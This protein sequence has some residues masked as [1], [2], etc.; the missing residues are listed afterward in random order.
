MFHDRFFPFE[1]NDVVNQTDSG[2]AYAFSPS[3]L[4]VR[5]SAE[6]R[7]SPRVER[8]RRFPRPTAYKWL[9][10]VPNLTRHVHEI[11]RKRKGAPLFD[12]VF[13]STEFAEMFEAP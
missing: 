7:P 10:G 5:V 1:L 4:S 8:V 12:V 11:V 13:H 9:A 2:S 3:S 6:Q